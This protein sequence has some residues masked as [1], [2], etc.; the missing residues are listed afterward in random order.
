MSDGSER[1]VPPTTDRHPLAAP[2]L[3]GLVL[4]VLFVGPG[5]GPGALLNLDLVA[6]EHLPAPRSFW[7]LGPE[8]G[9]AVPFNLALSGGARLVGGDTAVKIYFLA[10]FTTAF[11]A[12]YRMAGRLALGSLAAWSAAALYTMNPWLLT[13]VSVGHLT[14]AG[15]Y[16]LLPIVQPRLLRPSSSGARTFIAAAVLATMG[17]YGGLIAGLSLAAGLITER[18]RRPLVAL[19]AGFAGQL[20]WFT[21]GLVLLLQSPDLVDADAFPAGVG[22]WWGPFRILVGHGFWQRVLQIGGEPSISTLLIGSLFAVLS[23]AGWRVLPHGWRRPALVGAAAAAVLLLAES[24]PGLRSVYG[25]ATDLPGLGAIRTAHRVVPMISI[26]VCV[27][28]SAGATRLARG[29]ARPSRLATLS[30]PVAA[31]LVLAVP[32]FWGLEGTLEPVEIPASWDEARE[33]TSDDGTV[34]V[35]PWH[36]YQN[37]SV[38]D[39]RRV[40]NPA[41]P[42]FGPDVVVSPDLELA[43][44]GRETSD[45]RVDTIESLLPGLRRGEP[46]A[47][48]LAGAGIRWIV[49]FHDADYEQYLPLL[50]DPG[51]ESRIVDR[52]IDL[53]E[54]PASLSPGPVDGPRLV[55]DRPVAPL[56]RVDDGAGGTWAEPWAWGWMQGLRAASEGSTGLVVLPGGSSVVWY[57][58]AALVA[59]SH[60][61]WIGGLAWSVGRARAGRKELQTLSGPATLGQ[62]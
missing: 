59:A 29:A 53:V 45:P 38:A 22:G 16:A 28:V 44:P 21:P 18:R 42:F 37:I 7:G 61:A 8:L 12:M 62:L 43:A 9:R 51:L 32:G 20:V 19:G 55:P 49:I 39:D 30:L 47:A 56:A 31:A 57:W 52:D 25:D 24:F 35:L 41:I 46:V 5:L 23:V 1:R 6:V 58:P 3:V 54:V 15:A 14:F 17:V 26:V 33:L 11:V 2:A 34:L 13:R 4:G 10:V 27:A 60:A 40:L 36:R 50:G 48:Q